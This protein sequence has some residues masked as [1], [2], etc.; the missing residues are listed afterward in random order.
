MKNADIKL[1]KFD[2]ECR[3]TKSEEKQKVW[4]NKE[5]QSPC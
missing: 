1:K 4:I 5:V 2:K 3:K